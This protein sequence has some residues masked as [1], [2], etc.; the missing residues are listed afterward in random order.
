M[1]TRRAK[2]LIYGALYVLII[3]LLVAICYFIFI[4]P[5]TGGQAAVNCAT[6][7]CTPTSTAEITTSSVSMF[8]TGAGHYTFLAQAVDANINFGAQILSYQID[9]YDAAGTLI[10]SV[11]AQS[12]IYPSQSKYLVVP[13]ITVPEPVDHATLVVTGA[14]WIT[15]STL[16]AIPQFVQQN[17]QATM[18]SSSVAVSG[19]LTNPNIGSFEKVIILALFINDNG[20]NVIGVSQTELDNIQ[21]QST[22]NFSVLY[23][24]E[25]GIDPANNQIIIYAIR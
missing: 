12:F 23:P 13:N 1:S 15:S 19:Q 2:Q 24:V 6:N 11:P 16:G 20:G 3:L 14:S 18:S 21:P 22:N 4:R 8:V 9:L 7:I 10:E 17:I 25:P 5:F